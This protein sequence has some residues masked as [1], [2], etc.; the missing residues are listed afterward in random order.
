MA[1]RRAGR[2]SSQPADGVGCRASAERCQE[3]PRAKKWD[4][5]ARLARSIACAGRRCRLAGGSW[6]ADDGR[7]G[8]RCGPWIRGR[9]AAARTR[10]R[11]RCAGFRRRAVRKLRR[12]SRVPIGCRSDHRSSAADFLPPLSSKSS[13]PIP[14]HL[15]PAPTPPSPPWP[16]PTRLSPS[17]PCKRRAGTT[18][19]V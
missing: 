17:R 10:A 11:E 5:G 4:C 16:A 6:Q 18:P 13:A 2:T 8:R 19:W 9:A 1:G 3:K 14:R 7:T 12:A 15:D